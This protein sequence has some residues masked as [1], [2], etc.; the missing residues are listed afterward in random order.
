MVHQQL[1]TEGGHVLLGAVRAHAVDM[2]THPPHGVKPIH[3]NPEETM[4][5]L[6]GQG[7]AVSEDVRFK[8]R[9]GS[10]A[11]TPEGATMGIFNTH[12]TDPLQYLCMEFAEQDKSWSDRG[13]QGKV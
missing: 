2:Q 9:P 5:F 4:Y 3:T 6:R 7:E 10:L 13:Y 1:F 11:Y 8:V 12:D